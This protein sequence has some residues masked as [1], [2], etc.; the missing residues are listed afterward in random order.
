MCKGANPTPAAWVSKPAAHTCKLSAPAAGASPHSACRVVRRPP[1]HNALGRTDGSLCQHPGPAHDGHWPVHS[2]PILASLM[3][4]SDSTMSALPGPACPA[5]C[6][7]AICSHIPATL[8][9]PPPQATPWAHACPPAPP[10]L[11][12]SARPAHCHPCS[13][14]GRPRTA[15]S[16]SC[17]TQWTAV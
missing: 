12:G 15:P 13:A 1:I 16:R 8:P 5:P 6:H 11:P 7:H 14:P 9:H 2:P 3:C 4:M 10:W 17:P